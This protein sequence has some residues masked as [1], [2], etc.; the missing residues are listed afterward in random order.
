[1][2]IVNPTYNRIFIENSS[3]DTIG[4]AFFVRKIF[5]SFLKNEEVVIVTS[6]FHE[7]RTKY[8]F[9]KIWNFTPKVP[10][11]KLNFVGTKTNKDEFAL[12]T[13]REIVSL[14]QTKK[15]LSDLRN[16]EEFT[17]WLL[18]EHDTYNNYSSEIRLKRGNI[19]ELKY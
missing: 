15:T 12:R 13:E 5:Y 8:I 4:A 14:K 2:S 9:S 16:I 3:F 19:N 18:T 1:M 17:K 10:V 11:K 6:D 7:D